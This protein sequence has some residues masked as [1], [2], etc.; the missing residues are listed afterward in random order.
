MRSPVPGQRRCQARWAA[1]PLNPLQGKNCETV[2]YIQLVRISTASFTLAAVGTHCRVGPG[3]SENAR[4]SSRRP[5]AKRQQGESVHARTHE[6]RTHV[7][8]H[9][10]AHTS[11]PTSTHAQTTTLECTRAQARTDMHTSRHAHKHTRAHTHAHARTHAHTFTR[12][13]RVAVLLLTVHARG[14]VRASSATPCRWAV[15]AGHTA[16]NAPSPSARGAAKARSA[17][18]S[19]GWG[20]S[21]ETADGPEQ[22]SRPIRGH[23]RRSPGR[24]PT[25]APTLPVLNVQV[26]SPLVAFARTYHNMYPPRFGRYGRFGQ[27]WAQTGRDMVSRGRREEDREME[28]VEKE[29]EEEMEARMRRGGR[30]GG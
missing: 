16:G 7:R 13:S 22:A 6:A 27:R 19:E 23:S 29:M 24:L 28:E 4:P 15:W 14:E 5:C 20:S 1:I 11:A 3:G 9:T 10:R 25:H 2:S 21:E 12:R 26:Q 8:T 17:R 18:A 30:T